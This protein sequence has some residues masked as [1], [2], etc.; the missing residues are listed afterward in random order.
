MKKGTAGGLPPNNKQAIAADALDITPR[1]YK[2]L[3]KLLDDMEAA[4]RDERMTMP[5]RISGMIA[6]ARIMKMM[7]DLRK[8]DLNAGAGSAVTRYAEAFKTAHDPSRGA[9]G[10]GPG[11]VVPFD[12]SEPDEDDIRDDLDA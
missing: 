9:S 12:R 11:L 8:G 3:D 2:Q 6:L 4:D 10:P 7:Q 1:L 5:Q